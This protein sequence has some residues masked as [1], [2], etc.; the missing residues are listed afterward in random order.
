MINY[1]SSFNSY[2]TDSACVHTHTHTKTILEYGLC[3][4]THLAQNTATVV[5][6]ITQHTT[7]QLGI[8]PTKKKG[9]KEGKKGRKERKKRRKER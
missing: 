3:C 2:L 9:R 4:S 5:T 7:K 6:M 8:Q 1:F